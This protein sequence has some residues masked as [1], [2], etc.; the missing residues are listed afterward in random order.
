MSAYNEAGPVRFFNNFGTTLKVERMGSGIV[1]FLPFEPLVVQKSSS[2]TFFVKAGS[3]LGYFKYSDVTQP[4][5]ADIDTLLQLLMAWKQEAETEA[6]IGHSGVE[7]LNI[8]SM[9][10]ADAYE[11]DEV[12]AGGA[13]SARVI[14]E[15]VSMSLPGAAIAKIVRQSKTYVPAMMGSSTRAFVSGTLASQPGAVN[16]L[17]RIG[18]FDDGASVTYPGSVPA[19]NGIFFQWDPAAADLTLVYRSSMSG[20]QVDTVVPRA[21]WNIDLL[22]GTGA[23]PVPLNATGMFTFVFDWSTDDT[24]FARAGVYT[25]GHI[26][27]CH[28]FTAAMP[29]ILPFTTRALPVRWEAASMSN[30]SENGG[31]AMLQGGARVIT[32]SNAGHAMQHHARTCMYYAPVPKRLVEADSM[33]PLMTLRLS[34]SANRARLV[35]RR[36]VLMN[37]A[38][39][40]VGRWDLVINSTLSGASFGPAASPSAYAV[41]STAE[42]AAAGGSIVASGYFYDMAPVDVT[43]DIPKLLAT[44]DG[45]PDMLTLIVTNM[46]SSINVVAGIEWVEDN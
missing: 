11:V 36:L 26:S 43:L 39:S 13:R 19:G 12:A 21:N 6:A 41:V 3:F 45:T 4:V 34:A 22:D 28:K 38:S 10:D 35:P 7:M 42:T 33:V 1:A 5:T 31:V 18:V 29:G 15:S 37:L 8:E 46:Q 20:A 9:Y 2:N 24:T 44:I 23:T 17:N 16:I 32:M 30:W 14:G 25:D 27:Y 40:G